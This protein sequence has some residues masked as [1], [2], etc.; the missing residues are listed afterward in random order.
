VDA[1]QHSRADDDAGQAALERVEVAQPA[2][3]D[4]RGGERHRGEHRAE[5]RRADQEVVQGHDRARG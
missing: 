1:D 4:Q 2:V 5:Q 3:H